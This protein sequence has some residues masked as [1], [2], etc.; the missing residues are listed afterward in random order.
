MGNKPYLII[1]TGDF[2][3]ETLAQMPKGIPSDIEH[4]FFRACDL[5]EKTCLIISVFKGETLPCPSTVRAVI[6]TGSYA[7]IND[8]A[9]WMKTTANWLER[10]VDYN[11]PTLGVCFGHQ[12][13]AYAL[14]GQIATNDRGP[15]YGTVK[16]NLLSEAH[17][18][19]VFAKL[20]ENIIVQSCHYDVVTELPKG[21]QI[22]A[23][24][25]KTSCQAVRFGPCIW[26]TQSHPE[27]NHDT[28]TAILKSATISRNMAGQN[29][30]PLNSE[31]MRLNH[32]PE[33]LN[34]FLTFVEGNN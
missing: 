11:V 16:V 18:D 21:A 30:A 15:E 1:K 13:L 34:N 23:K 3:R 27:F 32:G 19:P 10:M 17:T 8:I 26:G 4:Y 2:N 25:T 28:M 20:P 14:G 22:L 29:L 9:P 6:I 33:I 12:L 7:S 5:K 24:N 31:L